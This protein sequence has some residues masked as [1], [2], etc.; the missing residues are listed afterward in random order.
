MKIVYGDIF[1]QNVNA[2]VNPVN[3]IG[4]MG[5][6]LAKQFKN[7]YP[8]M[9]KDYRRQCKIRD[10][11]SCGDYLM[12]FVERENRWIINLA[13]KNHW[14][15]KSCLS[16]IDDGLASISHLLRVFDNI[17][18]IAIPALGCGLGELNWINVYPL[19]VKH[20]SALSYKI[21]IILKKEVDNSEK[22]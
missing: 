3:C 8:G 1:E 5:A 16:C 15:D 21:L 6:G 7:R 12:Y 13:T 18:S 4:V 17:N 22:E 19:F 20:L 11:F 14:R 9:Y 10:Y 2:L